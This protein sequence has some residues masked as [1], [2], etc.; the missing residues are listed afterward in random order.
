LV[1]VA[2]LITL[3]YVFIFKLKIKSISQYIFILVCSGLYAYFTIKLRRYPEEAIHLLEYG[4][5]SYFIFKA[6][7][8]RIQDW[9]V[10]ITALLFA[11]FI[12][13][14]DEFIQWIMPRRYWGYGD[15]RINVLASGLFLLAV[16]K[17]IRPQIICKPL[18]KISVNML[19][20]IL[21]FNVIF[22]GLCL[23]NTPS[24]VKR[25]TATFNNLLWL[26]NE[27]PMTEYGYKYKDPDIGF[28]YSRLTLEELRETDLNNG[29]EFG[30]ILRPNNSTK[31]ADKSLIEIYTPY[32]SSFLYEFLLHILRRDND[33]RKL[34]NTDSPDEKIEISN[35]AYRENLLIEKYFQKTLK[36][37]GLKW[38]DKKIGDLQKTSSLQEINYISGAGQMI[39]AFS[40]KTVWAIILFILIIVLISAVVWKRKLSVD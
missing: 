11:L 37:S 33:F 29:E 38:P 1:V 13:T 36:H 22:L 7:S 9:T 10:Y 35:A 27:E 17:G 19:A 30:K 31:R 32:T 8:H 23:S 40:L 34:K 14:L 4:L 2:S 39:T 16:W 20:G 18:K 26:R 24:T 25:Y 6:L 12:G 21:S 5:L 3:L 15:I 28:F